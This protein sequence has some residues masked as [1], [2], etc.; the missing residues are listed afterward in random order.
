MKNLHQQLVSLYQSFEN[1]KKLNGQTGKQ[2]SD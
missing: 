2:N 1:N